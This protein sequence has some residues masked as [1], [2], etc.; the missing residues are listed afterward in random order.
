MFS[1]A[2][3]SG[4][5]TVA[6]GREAAA[7][8]SEA[9]RITRPRFARTPDRAAGYGPWQPPDGAW[10]PNPA[11]AP[12]LPPPPWLGHAPPPAGWAGA[13]GHIVVVDGGNSTTYAVELGHG[14]TVGREL[15]CSIVFSD[16]RVGLHQVAIARR[17]EGWLV[18]NVDPAHP[19]WLVDP[20]GR[21]QPI[22]WEIG[23]RSGQL[24]IG[25]ATL[26]LYPVMP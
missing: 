9:M 3:W 19:T 25:S 22:E 18:Q 26:L 12:P 17:G 4:G 6:T 16:P 7:N 8:P 24:S 15:G 20:M 23:L 11:Y 2:D 21:P 13:P 10:L 14:L 1:G 5:D